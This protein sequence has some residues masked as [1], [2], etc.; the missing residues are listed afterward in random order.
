MTER[1]KIPD[2]VRDRLLVE[3]MHRCCLCPEHHDI[4]EIHHIVPL[5]EGGPDT[6]DNLMVVCGTCHDK[7]HRICNRYILAFR[8]AIGALRVGYSTVLAAG[9]HNRFDVIFSG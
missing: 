4:T 2:A 8:L 3:A 7:I 9:D 6:E 5:R 1:K